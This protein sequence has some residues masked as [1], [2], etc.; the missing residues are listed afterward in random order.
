MAETETEDGMEKTF[1]MAPES[2]TERPPAGA[3]LAR[4]T[5]QAVLVLEDR[6]VVEHNN[7]EINDGEVREML[8]GAEEP[9]REA[10]I[11]AV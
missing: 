9:F 10:V 6:M 1:G 2:T 5:V 7:E 3:G 11:V 4:L 8:K